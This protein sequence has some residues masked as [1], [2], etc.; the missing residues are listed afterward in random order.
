MDKEENSGM[1]WTPLDPDGTNRI[2]DGRMKKSIGYIKWKQ[3]E[4]KL[5]LGIK[6][7]KKCTSKLFPDENKRY[8][9][10]VHNLITNWASGTMDSPLMKK[11][12]QN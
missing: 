12:G 5:Y 2:A 4:G 8:L 6:Q 10:L 1:L 9:K 7:D 11:I 3:T